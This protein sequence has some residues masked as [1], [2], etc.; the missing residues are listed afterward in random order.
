MEETIAENPK[1][2]VLDLKSN[3]IPAKQFPFSVWAKLARNVLNEEKNLFCAM[4]YNG[5]AALRQAIAEHLY[6]YRALSV[7]PEQ[8]VI[9][10]G[11][12]TLYQYLISFL[13]RDRIYGVENPGYHNIVKMY[14]KAA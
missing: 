9:G 4:P 1:T 3:A 6:T 10:A 2:D 13:G 5:T 8:I 11:T 12:E 7:S 14:D